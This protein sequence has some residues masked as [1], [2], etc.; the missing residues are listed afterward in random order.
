MH[1]KKNS[2]EGVTSLELIQSR[3][4]TIDEMFENNV[5]A[6]RAD[7]SEAAATST[8]INTTKPTCSTCDD[9]D[10][11]VESARYA[12]VSGSSAAA[13]VVK[14]DT[15]SRRHSSSSSRHHEDVRQRMYTE[16]MRKLAERL[17][18]RRRKM[19]K[20]TQPAAIAAA[21]SSSPPT[22]V[23][24]FP[25]V[26]RGKPARSLEEEF[27]QKARKRMQKLGISQEEHTH[28]GYGK[29]PVEEED[30]PSHLRELIEITDED[31]EGESVFARV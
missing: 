2:R 11:D 14:Y 23:K 8:K 3:K 7:A 27:M 30:L 21:T 26:G 22:M 25:K 4:Q 28:E 9:D 17:E 13:T 16:Y 18:R 1:A 5:R 10:D 6:W 19:M 24:I 12:N 31:D 15:N 29:R 20:I